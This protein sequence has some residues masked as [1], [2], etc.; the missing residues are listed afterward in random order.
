MQLTQQERDR[1]VMWLDSYARDNMGLAE[2]MD[3]LGAAGPMAV[4]S[5]RKKAE[6]A[7]CQI[8]ADILK[9]THFDTI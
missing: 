1:L 9:N 6:A 8:V 3:K 7:A 2:Q 4:L 5:R